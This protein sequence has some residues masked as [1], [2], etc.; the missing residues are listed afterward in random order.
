MFVSNF[1][2]SLAWILG[3][4]VGVSTILLFYGYEKIRYSLLWLRGIIEAHGILPV[5]YAIYVF[6]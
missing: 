1:Q 4:S 6:K 5:G 2:L 3:L